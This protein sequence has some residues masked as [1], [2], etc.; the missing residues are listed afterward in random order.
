M[1]VPAPAGVVLAG[2]LVLEA[3]ETLK[4]PVVALVRVDGPQRG[5]DRRQEALL[6]ALQEGARVQ[7]EVQLGGPGGA[8]QR[9]LEAQRLGRVLPLRVG[10]HAA[11]ARGAAGLRQLPGHPAHVAGLHHQVGEALPRQLARLR[12]HAL[13]PGER[14]QQRRVHGAGQAHAQLVDPHLLVIAHQRREPAQDLARRLG[15]RLHA[16]TPPRRIRTS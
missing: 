9:H 13:G 5:L 11:R 3:F 14:V 8:G 15:R 16:P 6:R 7:H 1:V 2:V 4:L 12:G 10:Q